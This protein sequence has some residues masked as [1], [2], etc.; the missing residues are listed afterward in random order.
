[1]TLKE[2]FAQERKKALAAKDS[3]CK[4]DEESSKQEEVLKEEA[5]HIFYNTLMPLF[6][7]MHDVDPT[8]S[9]LKVQ[10]DASSNEFY[11]VRFLCSNSR[12]EWETYAYH[13]EILPHTKRV[14]NTVMEVAKAE[15][16]NSK[17]NIEFNGIGPT[18][19]FWMNLE[20]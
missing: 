20:N 5:K 4:A 17:Q 18:I 13:K 7:K 11:T 6:E 8:K 2:R 9:L 19:I 12:C 10:I 3:C 15:G 14:W 16:V 1:M